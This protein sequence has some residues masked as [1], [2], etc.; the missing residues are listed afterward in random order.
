MAGTTHTGATWGQE[1]G[2][3][4]GNKQ[5]WSGQGGTRVAKRVLVKLFF[6]PGCWAKPLCS[7]DL[8][9]CPTSPRGGGILQPGNGCGAGSVLGAGVTPGLLML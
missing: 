6:F 9:L 2:D 1:G 4:D 3:A 7:S 5:L 8:Y